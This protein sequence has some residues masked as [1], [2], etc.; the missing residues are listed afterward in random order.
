MERKII[1]NDFRYEKKFIINHSKKNL[2]NYLISTSHMKFRIHHKQRIVN[3]IYLD[4]NI[5]TSFNQNIN[6]D[7]QRSKFRIRWY[8]DGISDSNPNFEIKLK[9][10]NLGEKLIYP[11]EEGL[12]LDKNISFKKIRQALENI[13]LP[14]KLINPIKQLKPILFVKYNRRYFIS[15]LY[16]CR[17]TLDSNIQFTKLYN[18]SRIDLKF[19]NST[20]N[21]VIELK[22]PSELK[23][24]EFNNL[25]QL[26]IRLTR[27]SKYVSGIIHTKRL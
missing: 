5:L 7:N 14:I 11:L 17:L 13:D 15:K 22:Y 26:P 8:G 21:I 1:R 24:S 16:P 4:T 20:N 3:S 10:N 23:T 18:K 9:N 6:G 27:Y 19:K 2:I 25:V 12:D